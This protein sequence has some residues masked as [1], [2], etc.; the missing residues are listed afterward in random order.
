MALSAVRRWPLTAT[1]SAPAAQTSLTTVCRSRSVT[2]PSSPSSVRGSTSAPSPAS[3]VSAASSIRTTMPGPLT[4]T[5]PRRRLEV[6]EASRQR[7]A[8]RG[9]S[10]RVAL[11]PLHGRALPVRAGA[12]RRRCRQRAARPRRPARRAPRPPNRPVP[13]PGRTPSPAAAPR[14]AGRPPA[15]RSARDRRALHRTRV[16]LPPGRSPRPASPRPGR[17]AAAS[18]SARWRLLVGAGQGGRRHRAHRRRTA[19]RA[20]SLGCGPRPP[21]SAP[22]E[23]PTRCRRRPRPTRA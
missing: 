1:A 14:R 8:L 3:P 9:E 17:A 21:T 16:E 4:G 19:H 7:R 11:G 23:R 2:R 18:T 20:V 15:A 13:G 5:G 10:Q 12:G 6:A 22:A